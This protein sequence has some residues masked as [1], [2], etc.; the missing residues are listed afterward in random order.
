M[1]IWTSWGPASLRK[2]AL[3][4]FA[5]ARAS[6]VLPVPGGPA[7]RKEALKWEKK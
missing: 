1:N 2:M 6:S 4:W 7:E 5:H 3:V